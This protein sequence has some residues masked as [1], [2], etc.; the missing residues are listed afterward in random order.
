MSTSWSDKS[1]EDLVRLAGAGIGPGPADQRMAQAEL[2]RR[3]VESSTRLVKSSRR[4]EWLS[5]GLGFLTVALV[6]LTITLIVTT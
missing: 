3:L 4:L 5:M 2:I 1:G 6:G